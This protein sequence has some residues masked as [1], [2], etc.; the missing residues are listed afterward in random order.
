MAYKHSPP[1][2]RKNS[3]AGGRKPKCEALFDFDGASPED[4]QFKKGEILT[5]KSMTEDPNW[6][7][8]VNS[9][10]DSGMIP[11]NYVELLP[12]GASKVQRSA[13]LPRDA[14]GQVLPM[15]WFHGKITRETAEELLNQHGKKDGLYM[16]R[17]STN[18]PGDYTLCVCFEDTI[19][20][21]RIQTIDGKL[22]IDE[23]EFFEDL[24]RLIQHY[25]SDPDGLSTKLVDP[26]M[27]RAGAEF[28]DRT[29]FNRWEIDPKYLTKEQLIGSGQFGEVYEGTYKG[30]KVAIKTLKNK[31]DSVMQEFLSEANVMT[32][33][34]H[35]NLVLLIG[36]CTKNPV[37]I[38][39]EFMAKGCL[40]DFLRSRGRSVITGAVQLGFVKDIC[41]AMTYLEEKNFV[42]RDLAAR[43]ILLS[44]DQVAK[45][46]DFGLAKDSR[47]G[48]V[49]LGKLPIKWTA[50]EALR[51]KV[52]TS[53]SDVWS[54]GVVMWEIYSF[55]RAPYPRMSQKEVVEQVVKG[56][57]MEKPET[58]PKDL[59]EKV[60]KWCWFLDAKDRPSFKQLSQ[61]LK[62]FTVAQ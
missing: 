30:I 23:E 35:Q 53:K 27:K 38:V 33:M 26:L 6:W 29:R 17:E 25:K 42:H 39:S 52:S 54:F 36:V 49:D 43:N 13:T 22:T 28:I 10:G 59:Y 9:K 5:V 24:E 4:L 12:E 2:S 50:P 34:K 14:S 47:L 32:Q 62:K 45:V 20:H 37:M 51:Q 8:A 58:C 16:I 19:D 15:P 46:S 56:Y 61:K 55:G 44:A 31:S 3:V 48:Q 18:F 1:S 60:I 40:L 57:R 11:A 21:Y 41:A 7:L